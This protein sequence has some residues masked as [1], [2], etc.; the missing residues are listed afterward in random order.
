MRGPQWSWVLDTECQRI[1]PPR[2]SRWT[3]PMVRLQLTARRGVITATE[4]TWIVPFTGLS[5]RQ[6]TK[7]VT[8]LRRPGVDTARRE[9]ADPIA[10]R[11]RRGRA[12]GRPPAFDRDSYKQ[13][14]TVE[15]CI[16]KLKQWRV[17]ATRYDTTATIY[18]APLRLA[19]II[20][21]SAVG[22]RRT[23]RGVIPEA[24]STR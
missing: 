20:V 19:G 1:R 5:P 3:Y 12:G 14:N 4:P 21:W 17:L 7:L 23:V 9:P 22:L 16:K 10:K 24:G 18:F 8:T 2:C 11:D 13:R 6:F 15:R